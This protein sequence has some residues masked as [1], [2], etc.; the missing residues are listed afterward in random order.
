LKDGDTDYVLQELRRVVSVAPESVLTKVI[1]EINALTDEEMISACKL[2]M[3]SGADFV[4]T[5]TGWIP[6]GANIE[7]IAKIKNV[8]RG[9]IKV[10][11]AGGIRPRGEFD[12]LLELGVERFGINTASALEIVQ[13]FGPAIC[14]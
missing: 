7:R 2:V 1:I 3:D 14:A 6:G 13:S 9:G 4:K 8:T 12:K 5:G 11:A 10:K